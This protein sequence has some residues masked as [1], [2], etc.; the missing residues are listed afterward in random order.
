M[1]VLG[2]N[3]NGVTSSNME[4]YVF[5]LNSDLLAECSHSENQ[6]IPFYMSGF[7]ASCIRKY[8]M[9]MDS[10][11]LCIAS[12]DIS[13]NDSDR[14]ETDTFATINTKDKSSYFSQVNKCIRSFHEQKSLPKVYA[15]NNLR[16]IYVNLVMSIV[17]KGATQATPLCHLCYICHTRLRQRDAA[18]ITLLATFLP[19]KRGSVKHDDKKLFCRA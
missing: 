14:I 4:E 7:I 5:I 17:M 12:E 18:L 11:E 19:S 3:Q 15:S 9:C 8:S 2:Q 1:A 6:N 10:A 16:N 13:N